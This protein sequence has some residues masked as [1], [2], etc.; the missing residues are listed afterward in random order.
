LRNAESS[1][2]SRE[3]AAETQDLQVR[4][5]RTRH[6]TW[7][8]AVLPFNI[9]MGPVG[10]L[11]Q[12]LILNLHGTVID[13]GLAVTLFNAVSVPSAIVWGFATDRFHRRKMTIVVSY[14]VT[15]GVLVSFLFA[16]S[17]YVVHCFTHCFHLYHLP[18]RRR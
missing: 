12:L 14:L 17:G 2:E 7:V 1:R 13:V 15:A 4:P 8:N 18:Q 6:A 5:E 16:N 11:I 3:S 10:T 9:A